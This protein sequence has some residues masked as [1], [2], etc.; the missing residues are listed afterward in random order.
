MLFR[1]GETA[2]ELNPNSPFPLRSVFHP[3]NSYHLRHIPVAKKTFPSKFPF[4]DEN[5]CT[6][7]DKSLWKQ[8]NTS[9]AECKHYMR[10]SRSFS[11]FPDRCK[12]WRYIC[13]LIKTLRIALNEGFACSPL[14]RNSCTEQELQV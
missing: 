12:G 9:L 4:H 2:I 14:S 8:K 11:R 5:A 1:S 10:T 3:V 7:V 6:G 13:L